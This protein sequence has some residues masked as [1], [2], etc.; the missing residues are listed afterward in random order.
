M[1]DSLFLNAVQLKVILTFK[2][3]VKISW[4]FETKVALEE[5]SLGSKSKEKINGLL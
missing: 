1:G 3:L 2:L 5:L 4:D